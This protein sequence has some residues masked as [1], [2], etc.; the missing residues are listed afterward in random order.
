MPRVTPARALLLLLALVAGAS[1]AVADPPA[2]EL[3]T[4]L[5]IPGSHLDVGFTAPPS[6]STA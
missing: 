4:I 1:P 2:A 6:S 5:V 3:K